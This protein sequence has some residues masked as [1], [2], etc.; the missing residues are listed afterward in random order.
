MLHLQ[1]SL[2]KKEILTFLPVALLLLLLLLLNGCAVK[3]AEVRKAI[4]YIPDPAETPW[5]LTFSPNPINEN[6]TLSFNYQLSERGSI[7]IYDVSGEQIQKK[8]IEVTNGSNS[9][10]VPVDDLPD[11]IYIIEA[12]AGSRQLGIKRITKE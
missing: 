12:Y 9:I 8:E 2:M 3:H 4:L 11:G 5:D 1:T 7:K 6:I 10:L